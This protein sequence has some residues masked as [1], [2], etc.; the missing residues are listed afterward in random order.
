MQSEYSYLKFTNYTYFITI[1]WYFNTNIIIFNSRSVF[2]GIFHVWWVKWQLL[3]KFQQ[4]I[5]LIG[6]YIL[7]LSSILY[8]IG[9]FKSNHIY[10]TEW[11]DMN[12]TRIMNI[13]DKF[14]LYDIIYF[15]EVGWN[16]IIYSLL[17]YFMKKSYKNT[18]MKQDIFIFFHEIFHKRNIID[19][20]TRFLIFNIFYVEYIIEKNHKAYLNKI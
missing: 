5:C 20:K 4:I 1:L 14:W 10:F 17:K 2:Y 12:F 19:S 8:I 3:L 18:W 6:Y 11:F 13:L 9:K 16:K 7:M 15:V